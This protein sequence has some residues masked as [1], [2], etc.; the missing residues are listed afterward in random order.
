MSGTLQS[1]EDRARGGDAGAQFE[2]A[3][4]LDRAR[5][6]DEAT[7]WMEKAAAGGH[8]EA[9]AILAVS[10]LQGME[11]PRDPA[12]AL[13]RLTRAVSLGGNS[14]RRLLA[15][16]TAIGAAGPPDWRKAVDLVIEAAKAGD[17]QALRE[18]AL[19]VEMAAPSSPLSDDL[20]LRAGLKGDGLAGFAI[21]RRLTLHGRA[22][23]SE[24]IFAQWRDGIARIGHPLAHRITAVEPPPDTPLNRPEGEPDWNGV[25][26]LLAQPPGMNVRA[27]KASCEQ[28][29]IRRFEKLMTVE[30]CEYLIGLSTRIL[31][32]AEILDRSTG[33]PKQSRVRTNSVA[34][35]WPVH[36]DLVV[37]A[38]NLRL[39]AA[40]GLPW[41]NGELLNVLMYKPGEEYRVHYDFFPV[42]TAKVDPSGQRIRTLLVN[43]DTDY[44]GGETHFV[45][46]GLKIKGAPGDAMLF[47]NCDA[48]GAPDKTS[49]HA[50]LPVTRGQKWLL[51]KWFRE[52]RFAG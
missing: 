19:L 12:A 35:F 4:A 28:P 49:L 21:L 52:K 2:L 43:L 15:V 39:A 23:G 7:S 25:A 45:T 5:R 22:L 30:E 46:A 18:L 50:G 14:A 48:S 42:E 1:L 17:F 44:D 9:L 11:R 26:E 13:A 34:V 51:S 16:L 27:P 38:L 31:V 47:H 40:T 3:V 41:E 32:P 10:D 36:Q 8:V 29:V 20:L 24:R 33:T 37:H 6:R